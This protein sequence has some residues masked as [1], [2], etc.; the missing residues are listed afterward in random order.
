[1]PRGN[2]RDIETTPWRCAFVS[3]PAW[4]ID[5]FLLPTGQTRK[6]ERRGAPGPELRWHG[7]LFF[8]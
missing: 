5:C 6:H 1:V 2:A 4:L 8:V 3:L 7:P